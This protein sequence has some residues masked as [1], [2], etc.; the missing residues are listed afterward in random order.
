M[1]KIVEMTQLSPTMTEGVI[2]KWKKNEGDTVGPGEVLAEVE[3]DKANMDLEAF[4]KG[5]LLAKLAPEG[6]S[7]KVGAP[8]AIVGAPGEDVSAL[9]AKAKSGGGAAPAK[10]AD[11]SPEKTEKAPA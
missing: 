2:S 10:V 11:K 3:T 6:S 9:I 7:I 8:I 1:A 4:D 5:V